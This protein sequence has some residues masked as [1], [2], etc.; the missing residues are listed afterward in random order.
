[1]GPRGATCRR[2]AARLRMAFLEAGAQRRG[3]SC[4]LSARVQHRT[5]LSHPAAGE[6]MSSALP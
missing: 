1:M 4:S 6:N 2:G 3:S 5:G